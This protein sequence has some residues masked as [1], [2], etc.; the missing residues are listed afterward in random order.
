MRGNA[1]RT[2]RLIAQNAMRLDPRL[3]AGS[4][5]GFDHA[6]NYGSNELALPHESVLTNSWQWPSG[7]VCKAL[8]QIRC[9]IM[10]TRAG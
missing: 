2:A 7:L 5:A 4:A 6:S 9:E 8:P 1:M 3:P 10:D